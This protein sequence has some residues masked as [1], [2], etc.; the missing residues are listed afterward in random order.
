M[1]ISD[2]QKYTAEVAEK[3]GLNTDAITRYADLVSE[4]GE[5]GAELVKGTSYGTKPIEAN[6][7]LAMEMGDV[8][9][10]LA[11]LANELDLNMKECFA[12][13]MQKCEERMK[14][15][16]HIGSYKGDENE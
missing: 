14:Q 5:L 6:D 8:I 4:I 9:F 12:K 15:K 3:W 10:V 7:N 1:I 16:G 11:L 13:T 2:I